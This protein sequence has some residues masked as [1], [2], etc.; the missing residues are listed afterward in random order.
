[1]GKEI[2]KTQVLHVNPAPKADFKWER[3][4]NTFNFE[5]VYCD[6]CSYQWNL[7]D[8]STSNEEKVTHEFALNGN[9]P[10][11]LIITNKLN[12]CSTESTKPL[13]FKIKHN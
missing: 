12:G 4:D 3:I 7:G 6:N 9:Y 11:K 2:T 10:I 5:A 13:S 1:M 8:N